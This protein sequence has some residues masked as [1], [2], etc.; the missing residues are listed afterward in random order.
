MARTTKSTQVVYNINKSRCE[1][2]PTKKHKYNIQ[3]GT[4]KVKPPIW[5]CEYCNNLVRS[6]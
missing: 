3:K 2:S 6:T 1:D 5:E 4:G